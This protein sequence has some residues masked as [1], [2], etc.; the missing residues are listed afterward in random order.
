MSKF[1]FINSAKKITK[2][3]KF[4]IILNIKAIFDINVKSFQ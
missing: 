2:N 4:I 3:E 1:F